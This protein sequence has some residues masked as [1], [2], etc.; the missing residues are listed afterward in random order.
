MDRED[1]RTWSVS[2]YISSFGKDFVISKIFCCRSNA[3]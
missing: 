3:S 1:L 2:E